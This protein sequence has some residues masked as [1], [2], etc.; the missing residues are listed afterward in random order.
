MRHL[1]RTEVARCEYS[2]YPC[3][4]ASTPACGAL[5]ARLSPNRCK[6]CACAS[7]PDWPPAIALP[8]SPARRGART[9]SARRS[10]FRVF[11]RRG[12]GGEVAWGR[13]LA[14]TQGVG[15]RGAPAMCHRRR[16]LCRM[17]ACPPIVCTS[18]THSA[19]TPQCG[20][21]ADF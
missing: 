21:Y 14:K 15:S 12:R 5:S 2:E 18:S 20:T 17:R 6:A 19:R 16:R 8:S 4:S 9:T 11:G 10:R 7:G 13:D 1:R 3:P